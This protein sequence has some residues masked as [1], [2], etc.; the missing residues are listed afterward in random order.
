[1]INK[2]YYIIVDQDDNPISIEWEGPYGSSPIIAEYPSEICFFN[3][4]KTPSDFIKR[5]PKFNIGDIS[6]GKPVN[7]RILSIKTIKL[8]IS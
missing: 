3:N 6:R 7:W 1:M 5:Y 2:S 4:L 8:V